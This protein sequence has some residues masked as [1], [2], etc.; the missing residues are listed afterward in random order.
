MS[1]SQSLAVRLFWLSLYAAAF[2]YL[3]GAVVVYLRAIYYPEGFGFPLLLAADQ[4]AAVEVGRELATLVMLLGAAGLAAR[5]AW[6]RFGAFAIAFGIWDLIFYLTLKFIL[7]WP[8]SL[9]TWDVLFLIPGVWTGPVWSAAIIAVLLVVCGA[10]IM[11]VDDA[12]RSPRPGWVGW[13]GASLSLALLLTAFLWNHSLVV[14]GGVP[15]T[16]PTWLWMVGVVAGLATFVRVFGVQ[17]ADDRRT[18]AQA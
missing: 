16:F 9:A 17:R 8:D 12:G 11:V 1:H 5:T 4:I 10:R 7:G 14:T 13:A 6:G 3:E 2:G 15:E 18:P